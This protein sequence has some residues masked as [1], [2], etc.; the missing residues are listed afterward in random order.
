MVIVQIEDLIVCP[1]CGCEETTVAM[2]ENRPPLLW[3]HGCDRRWEMYFVLGKEMNRAN[4]SRHTR[5]PK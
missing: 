4:G 3:C 2:A 5:D 1:R